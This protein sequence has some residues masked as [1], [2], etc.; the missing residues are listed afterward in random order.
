MT[1]FRSNLGAC[2]AAAVESSSILWVAGE[3]LLYLSEERGLTAQGRRPPLL[4]THLFL[5]ITPFKY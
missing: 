2:C 4:I 3:A 1:R 5:D